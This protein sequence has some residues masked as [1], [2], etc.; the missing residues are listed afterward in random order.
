MKVLT[1]DEMR[2]VDR[3]AIEAGMPAIVL[4]ENAGAR[5]VE[6]LAARFAPLQ[7][8]RI[9]IICGKGNNGG[10]GLVIARQLFTRFQPKSLHVLLASDPNDFKGEAAANFRMWQL[11]GG[12]VVN[13]IEPGMRA[14]TIVVDALL[15]TGLR[16]PVTGPYA[17]FIE[18]INSGF[19]QARVI[20][21]DVPSGK[22]RA[23]HTVTFVA[24]KIDQI[25]WPDYER[26]GELI[27]SPIGVPGEFLEEIRLNVSE[28][29]D[30]APLFAPR[31]RNS[32]KGLYGHVLVVAGSP[33]KT[34]AA[35]MTGL[36][37]LRAGA[38]LVTVASSQEATPAIASHAPE[39]M[40]EPLEDVT[41]NAIRNAAEGKTLVAV[42]P[43]LGTHHLTVEVVRRL[44]SG[45]ELPMVVD[46][47][48]LNALAGSEFYGTGRMRVLTPHPGEMSR[49]CGKSTGEVQRDR[50]GVARGFAAARNVTVVLK[51]ERT[52]IAFPD[53]RAWINPT[54]SPALATAGT[55][56]ILTGLI[57]GLMA[58]FPS[59]QELAVRA[60]VW[61]HGR[62]G[63]IGAARLTEK[64]FIATD[65][66]TFLPEAMRECASV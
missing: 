13:S 36:S 4:M 8:Q 60:A 33:G 44:F 7:S 50:L 3:R 21:V 24:P 1:P 32:N 57:A 53:G 43:G 22:A 37:A 46:A 18:E 23:D 42:G 12:K 52:V 19:P 62:A 38:G 9:V 6:F 27:V 10:D 30:F 17:G 34:G 47:D 16:G 61:L 65:V 54:G 25:L 20:G 56:D 35:A 31:T 51:G 45:I 63:E 41:F 26:S 5:V 49:L 14:A 11:C 55:G 28:P 39:L 15:G 29:R 66:L 40:T 58:Q 59:Q 48:A 2:E 64:A